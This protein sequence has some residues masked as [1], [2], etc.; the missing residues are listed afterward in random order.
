MPS[1][2]SAD[3]VPRPTSLILENLFELRI[4]LG[5]VELVIPIER[6]RTERLLFRRTERT[7]HGVSMSDEAVTEN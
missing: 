6:S 5:K 4:P 3:D 2:V 1:P 7:S